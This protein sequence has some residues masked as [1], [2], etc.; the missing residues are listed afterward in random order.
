[1]IRTYQERGFR[2]S[3]I[4]AML[5]KDK[6]IPEAAISRDVVIRYEIAPGIE[7]HVSREREI[8]DHSIILE[9]IRIAKAIV[10]GKV[11]DER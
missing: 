7:L 3:A 9:V 11:E 4:A 10:Q 6:V 1:L 8:G 5:K 2:I